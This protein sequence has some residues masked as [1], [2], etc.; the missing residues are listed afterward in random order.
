MQRFQLWIIDWVE[1]WRRP[2]LI[3][4]I[5]GCLDCS[6]QVFFASR[7]STA[8]LDL[9]KCERRQVANRHTD[10]TTQDT[11]SPLM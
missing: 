9:V 10:W 4:A 8:L 5:G 6:G 11:Q 7:S 3:D 1:D 2:L